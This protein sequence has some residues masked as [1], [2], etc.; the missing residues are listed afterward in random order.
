MSKV[1]KEI[2]TWAKRTDMET[3]TV[4]ML[5]DWV[6]EMELDEQIDRQIIQAENDHLS[7]IMV[8]K[9]IHG[10]LFEQLLNRPTINP[11]D[12]INHEDASAPGYRY[13][14]IERAK[15]MLSRIIIKM[16]DENI[17]NI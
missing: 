3:I 4:G 15:D 14:H 16:E 9:F 10:Y 12:L 6:S 2:L 5:K 8:L 7:D 1:S 11:D 13:D 17:E